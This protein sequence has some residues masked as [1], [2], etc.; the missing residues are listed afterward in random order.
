MIICWNL[1][2]PMLAQ[3]GK[4]NIIF[5][6]TDDQ[7]W[8]AL[9]VMGNSILQ[10]P[11]L[12]K[13][14][15]NGILFQNAYVT[16]SICCVSRA[17]VLSGMYESGHNIHDFTTDMSPEALSATYPHLLKANGYKLGFI[18]KYG[19]GVAPPKEVYDFWIN[20]EEGGKMQPDYIQTFS[21][22]RRMHDTDTL[23]HAIQTFLG[24]YAGK[25]PFYLSVSFKAPHE[26]DG[27]P[28]KYF[29]QPGYESMFK[30]VTIPYPVT[31]KE[32]YWNQFPDFFKTDT[33]FARARWKGL[34]GTPDLYQENVK[35]YYRLITGVD[36]AVGRMVAKL[37]ELGIEKN[38]VI[39]FMGDNGM[40]LGEKQ[41]EGKWFGYEASIRVPLI[42]YDP[43]TPDK[44]KNL[45]AQQIALNID[46]APTI[47]SLADIKAPD[48]MQ[49]VNLIDVVQGKIS[50]RE[51]F[52]YQHYFLGSPRIPMV[53]GVVTKDLKYMKFIEH[54]YEELFDIN[55][56]PHEINNL[57]QNPSYGKK[58]KMIRKVFNSMQKQYGVNLGQD[59]AAKKDVKF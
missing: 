43:R 9:G 42:V 18:G 23:D 3:K 53:E 1:P 46:I 39:V 12:D 25:A 37:K 7:R 57:V 17:S 24:E 20:S 5:I 52:F 26:Q 2:M 36:A 15:N 21:N 14:A 45:R 58:L 11:N 27:N 29:V 28:P 59:G 10:T 34:L 22:G 16:T 40:L 35:N 50:A 33:N 48:I 32:M 49:G 54:D 13:L 30:D 44:I 31:A 51:Q 8:D 41:I 47:L 4:P 38:T 6:I 55:Y 56:D 19:I